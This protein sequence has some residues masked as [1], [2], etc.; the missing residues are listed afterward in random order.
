MGCPIRT[1][2]DQR[3]LAAPH[4]FSQRATSFIASW[5]QGIHRMPLLRSR[6][7]ISVR[8]KIRHHGQEP[9]S[10]IIGQLSATND[11]NKVPA[12]GFTRS[13]HNRIPSQIPDQLR[14][15][16][17]DPN[18]SE[19]LASL[20]AALTGPHR[21]GSMGTPEPPVRQ[22]QRSAPRDAPEPDSHCQRTNASFGGVNGATHPASA[23]QAAPNSL[24][25]R[26]TPTAIGLTTDS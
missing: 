13:A 16:R 24:F 5:C 12:H 22:T 11:R 14:D 4:G 17:R 20:Q 10:V 26:D 3:L 18:V 2:T 19:R 21:T 25:L 6:S 23:G 8:T 7:W 1:S 15:S 9:S